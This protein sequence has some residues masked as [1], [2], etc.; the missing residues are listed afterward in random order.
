M[1]SYLAGKTIV[2]TKKSCYTGFRLGVLPLKDTKVRFIV[3]IF[4]YALL[5]AI[6]CLLLKYALPLLMP[7]VVALAV[8]AVLQ[9][10]TKFLS[11]HIK[12]IPKKGW[13]AILIVLA[14]GIVGVLAVLLCVWLI[15]ELVGFA[16]YIPGF[17]SDT[18][19][20]IESAT[21]E[22]I[23]DFFSGLPS[24][25]G[26]PMEEFAVNLSEDLP[27][28]LLELFNQ[29]SSQILSSIGSIGSGTIST[30][31]TLIVNV[32]GVIVVVIVTI[33][34]TFFFGLDYDNV[35]NMMLNLFPAKQRPTV[36]KIKGYAI[37]TVFGLLKTYFLLMSITFVELLSGFG[38]INLIGSGLGIK[39]EYVV[40]LAL[41]ISLIDIL[42]VLGVGT[43]LIPWA[44]ID[45]IIGNW[46][47]GLMI[48]LLYAFITIL[49]NYLEPKIIGT[50][51][52]TH[53]IVML[54]AIYVGG[55]LFGVIGV[56]ALPLTVIIIKRLYDVGAIRLPKEYYEPEENE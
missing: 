54:I 28:R 10:P 3:N 43:V 14:Y 8:A 21:R 36:L 49:R 5:I 33:I 11:E 24:W 7:F 27:G 39:I 25:I 32:P 55:S 51:Y 13:A 26:K 17:I 38:L 30:I 48:I 52:G 16:Q 9:K 31:L 47:L 46:Q 50:K 22:D 45:F 56:F 23:A 35:M 42:P 15:S 18:A 37:D 19:S 12:F 29:F 53:P 6:F 1:F 2:E 41:I 4:F 34:A 40:P 20:M 44:L